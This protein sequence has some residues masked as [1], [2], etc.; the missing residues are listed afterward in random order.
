[1]E[2]GECMNAVYRYGDVAGTLV[3]DHMT[4]FPFHG[5]LRVIRILLTEQETNTHPVYR[6][7]VLRA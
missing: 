1:M 7:E 6:D 4:R 3:W 2:L 5:C